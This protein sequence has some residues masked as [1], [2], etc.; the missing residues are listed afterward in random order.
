MIRA[1]LALAWGTA[2]ALAA[3]GVVSSLSPG[4]LKVTPVV[5]TDGRL[6]VSFSAAASFTED[7]KTILRSGLQV[8]FTYTVDV[9]RPSIWFDPTLAEVTVAASAKF[10]ALK[11]TYQVSKYRE[12]EVIKS[13]GLDQESQVRAW[14]TEFDSLLLE[15]SSPLVL[16]AEYY[17]RVRLRA[18]PKGSFSL[19]PWRGDDATGRADFTFIR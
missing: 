6:L 4:A 1:G 13:E 17:V 19:W 3:G 15:P 8:M 10:D 14:L 9:R 18:D 11:R 12:G 5:A 16:N 7:A 2:V